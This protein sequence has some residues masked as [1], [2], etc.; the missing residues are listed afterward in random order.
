MVLFLLF[1]LDANKDFEFVK[2]II[3]LD[4]LKQKEGMVD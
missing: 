3:D 2:C 1:L 4:I